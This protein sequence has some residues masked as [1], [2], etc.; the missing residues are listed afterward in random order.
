MQRKILAA[1]LFALFATQAVAQQTSTSITAPFPT[2]ITTGL[3]YQQLLAAVTMNN[4]HSLTIQNNN[5]TDNC[6][7]IVVGANSPWLVGDTTST[8]RTVNGTSITGAQASILLFPGG[9]Y[10][11][12]YPF[13]PPDQILGTCATTGDSLYIDTQ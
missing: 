10:T 3:T 6:Q 2:K 7:I 13:I 5:T 12:Y 1:C 11:R 8:A 9:S 4:R